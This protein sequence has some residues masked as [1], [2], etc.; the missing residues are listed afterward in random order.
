MDS[1]CSR[2]TTTDDEHLTCI[3]GLKEQLQW[4][5]GFGLRIRYWNRD[6]VNMKIGNFCGAVYEY[7]N[8]Y[9]H[10]TYQPSPAPS[11]KITSQPSLG[12]SF[13]PSTSP[14]ISP[15]FGPSE[16]P[17]PMHQ[18]SSPSVLPTPTLTLNPSSDPSG[19]PTIKPANAPSLKP[20]TN[21]STTPSSDPSKR[22]T[23]LF[24]YK[25]ACS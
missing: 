6:S 1:I 12:P 14:S 9:H 8:A 23:S 20:T 16:K 11:I 22:K 2:S 4:W 18:S 13:I 3:N 10:G 24:K 17:S 19:S 5:G 15:S 25:K 7:S 21:P